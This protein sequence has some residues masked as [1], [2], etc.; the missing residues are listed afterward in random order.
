MGKEY[1]L[2]LDIG[3][4]SVGWAVCD[5]NYKIPKFKG[6][7]MWGI[8]LFEKSNS[9]EER[10][11]FRSSRRRTQR[12]R[13]RLKLLEMLFDEE[14]SKI[15][16][17]FFI[18]L[19]E[20]NLYL[21]DKSTKIPYCVFSD[22]NY[23]DK[24]F[25]RDYP[26]IYHL[27]NEL[28]KS[29]KP[30]DVR[31]VYLALHHIIKNR[32]HF[33]FDYSYKNDKSGDF[34]PIYNDLKNYFYDNYEIELDCSDVDEFA[35]TLK[36]KSKGKTKKNA[37]IAELFGVSKKYD[38]VLYSALSLLSGSSVKLFDIFD[39]EALKDV[40]KKSVSFSSGFDDNANDFQSYL[41]ERFE[42][43]EKLKAVYDWAVLA[44]ILDGKEYISEAKVAI[45]EKHKRNI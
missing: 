37:E 2:G 17:A 44:D 39:D 26:T 10:R 41:G 14:I 23:T 11:G 27:R 35:N 4:D 5:T 24:D 31:L 45:Y 33:L 20:S 1:Y 30:H 3:T 25:H 16:P 19:R 28:I 6:N 22:E 29:N 34:M 40:E 18:K 9:A 32:G 21:E 36:D 42:L 12:K 43:L 7:A 13:E 38:K 15:D 8:R